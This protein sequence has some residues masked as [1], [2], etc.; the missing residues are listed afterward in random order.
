MPASK[1]LKYLKVHLEELFLL[2]NE[3]LFQ[4]VKKEA[5]EIVKDRINISTWCFEDDDL[6]KIIEDKD[7]YSLEQL[8]IIFSNPVNWLT[9]LKSYHSNKLYQ[10]ILNW[11]NQKLN[12][13]YMGND[14]LTTLRKLNRLDR[15]YSIIDGIE[16]DI[17]P[18]ILD[19]DSLIEIGEE[20]AKKYKMARLSD[21]PE[22]PQ[23][24]NGDKYVFFF[25]LPNS[26][27][28]KTI[29]FELLDFYLTNTK[30]L[31]TFYIIRK[32][33]LNCHHKQLYVLCSM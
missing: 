29:L 21:Y 8:E 10:T 5:Y 4:G 9:I 1:Q 17:R 2:N 23:I 25:Y 27:K 7:A 28:D 13:L 26:L 20:Q 11:N 32:S 22:M 19:I 15:V 3:L 18:L 33:Y 14:T 30:Y 6:T 12:Q 24:I 16:I 31:A